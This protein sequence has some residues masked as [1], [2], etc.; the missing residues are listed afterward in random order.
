MCSFFFAVEGDAVNGCFDSIVFVTTFGGAALTLLF[1]CVP[2]II[3]Y[4]RLASLAV[5][6][7]KHDTHPIP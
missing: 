5:I 1:V 2:L 7:L 3:E 4:V 6:D